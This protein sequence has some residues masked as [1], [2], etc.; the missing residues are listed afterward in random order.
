MFVPQS[1]E[2]IYLNGFIRP[3]NGSVQI[4]NASNEICF[5][6]AESKSQQN[7]CGITQKGLKHF[8]AQV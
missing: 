4:E 8:F 2:S 3:P 5:F 1:N 6:F 7:V